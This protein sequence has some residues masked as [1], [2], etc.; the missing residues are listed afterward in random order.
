MG[1]MIGISPGNR[2]FQVWGA[3]AIDVECTS[4]YRYFGDEPRLVIPDCFEM[5]DTCCFSCCC[6]R[7]VVFDVR[8][9]LRL[10][11]RLAFQQC[12]FLMSICIPPSV[13][14]IG[15]FCFE[16]C[17]ALRAVVFLLGRTFKPSQPLR[18][19]SA[20]R[21]PRF[22]SRGPSWFSDV[23]VSSLAA[24]SARSFFSSARDWSGSNMRVL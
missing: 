13:E 23:A 2:F 6:V 12:P 14:M 15:E 5:L 9:R 11:K 22:Q 10:M 17:S 7:E 8:S 16:M 1:A 21:W 3:F 4:I 20:H 19:Q 18:S 24:P